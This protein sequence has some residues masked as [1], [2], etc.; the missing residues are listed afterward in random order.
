MTSNLLPSTTERVI[1]HTDDEINER[2]SRRIE[3]NVNF[4]ATRTREF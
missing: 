4:Y 1:P 2:I 3:A